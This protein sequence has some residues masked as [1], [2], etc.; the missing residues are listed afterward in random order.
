MSF[1][2]VI[3]G[4]FCAFGGA[5]LLLVMG[6]RFAASH[7]GHNLQ[8]MF[9]PS[10]IFVAVGVCLVI[11]NRTSIRLLAV[12]GGLTILHA[13]TALTLGGAYIQSVTGV[14]FLILAGFVLAFLRRSSQG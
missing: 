13:L 2:R 1:I 4:L 9:W 8:P 7:G 12:I 10:W 5:L 11:C 6:N 3:G 14:I